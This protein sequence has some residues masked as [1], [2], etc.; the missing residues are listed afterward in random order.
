V[1]A[2][3][4]FTAISR[5]PLLAFDGKLTLTCH[6]KQFH[7]RQHGRRMFIRLSNQTCCKR[8][9][10]T[11][12]STGKRKQTVFRHFGA[13]DSRITTNKNLDVEPVLRHAFD[14]SLNQRQDPRALFRDAAMR[15]VEIGLCLRTAEWANTTCCRSTSKSCICSLQC[16]SN[17]DLLLVR[18]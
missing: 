2:K 15:Q 9:V 6:F 3:N 18:G 1:L 4:Q 12:G 5:M 11:A 7:H 10:W 13:G 17:F 8:K 16:V 14:N